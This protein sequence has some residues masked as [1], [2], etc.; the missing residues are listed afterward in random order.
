M[1]KKTIIDEIKM[2]R[3]QAIKEK[4]IIETV[5]EEIAF[6]EIKIKIAKEIINNS[7]NI[8]INK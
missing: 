7:L 8:I 4:L 3:S 6:G 2:M 5:N 1:L